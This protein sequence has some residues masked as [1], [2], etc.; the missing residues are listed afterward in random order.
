MVGSRAERCFLRLHFSGQKLS[1]LSTDPHDGVSGFIHEEKLRFKLFPNT[2]RQ[3]VGVRDLPFAV[4]DTTNRYYIWGTRVLDGDF[5]NDFA[6]YARTGDWHAQDLQ[7]RTREYNF[8]IVTASGPSGTGALVD[9]VYLLEV[10]SD[11]VLLSAL[12]P[13]HGRVLARLYECQRRGGRAASTPHAGTGRL[14]TVD[15]SGP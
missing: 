10:G 13:D 2:G 11:S 7:K 5:T 9:E 3:A 6:L 12:Y 4:A 8:P 1:R 14:E 15:L